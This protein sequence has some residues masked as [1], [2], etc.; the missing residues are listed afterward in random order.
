MKKFI[1]YGLLAII[2]F[3]A[4]SCTEELEAD[5]ENI[6]MYEGGLAENEEG[7]ILYPLRGAGEETLRMYEEC[8]A[9]NQEWETLYPFEENAI[10]GYMD[11]EGNVII[12][13]Q[14]RMARDFSEGLAFVIIDEP[15]QRGYINLAGELVITLSERGL[16]AYSFSEGFAHVIE[17]AWDFSIENP[18]VDSTPGP[19]IFIDRTG[20]NIFGQ[21][22]AS[23]FPFSEG[24]AIVCLMNGNDAFINRAGENAFDLEFIHVRYFEDDYAKVVLLDGTYTHIDRQGN[25]VDLGGW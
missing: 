9:E 8:L 13:P 16:A 5:E 22:F 14:F 10:W 1:F 4:V 17:R 7:E 24:L 20:Q 23:V 6:S 11:D 12:A 21:E 25:I 2:L 19:Y 18:P 3:T 15:R